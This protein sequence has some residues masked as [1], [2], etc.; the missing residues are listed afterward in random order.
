[1]NFNHRSSMRIPILLAF[2]AP[3]V[4]NAFAITPI[5]LPDP[6]HRFDFP[7][8]HGPH[9][10]FRRPQTV[11]KAKICPVSGLAPGPSCPATVEEIFVS[12]TEPR[13]V[14]RLAHRPG[15]A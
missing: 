3:L 7:E 15:A 4:A 11:V 13:S 1:M 10:D 9:P 6:A 12:G 8:D 14:C 2:V 5:A